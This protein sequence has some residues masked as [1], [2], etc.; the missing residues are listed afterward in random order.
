MTT[1]K[2]KKIVDAALTQSSLPISYL[3][4][5]SVGVARS[6]KTLSKK[7]IFRMDCDPDNSVSTGAGERPILAVRSMT[8][9]MIQ[10]SSPFIREFDPLKDDD[11]NRVVARKLSEGLHQGKVAKVV[12]DIV[13]SSISSASSSDPNES[14]VTSSLCSVPSDV[15]SSEEPVFAVTESLGSQ[16]MRSLDKISSFSS[17]F[18]GTG[19]IETAPSETNSVSSLD[20]SQASQAVVRAICSSWRERANAEAEASKWH[21][22]LQAEDELFGLQVILYFDSG[23]QPQFHEIV[24]A[25]NHN[26]SLA[27]IFIKLNEC[28]D[29]PCKDIFVDENGEVFQRKFPLP[30]TNKEM[31]SQFVHTMMCKPTAN[32]DGLCT[33]FMVI[34]THIDLIGKCDET[35]EDKNDKL[36]D[37]LLPTLDDELIMNGNDIIFPVNAKKPSEKDE[38]CFQ[39]IRQKVSD[40]N[41]AIQVNTPVSF[42]MFFTDVTKYGKQENKRVLELSEC[43]EIAFRLK[44]DRQT[45]EAALIYFDQMNMWMYLPSILPNIVFIDPQ[46]PLDSVN[47][48]VQ[49][50]YQVAEGKIVGFSPDELKKWKEGV[51]TSAMLSTD[52]FTSCFIKDIFEVDDAL[53][54]FQ[55]LFIVAPIKDSEYI[56][57]ANL[58]AVKQCDMHKYHPS[59]SNDVDPL[60]LHF[61]KCRIPNGI[62]CSTHACLR[63]KH[64]WTTSY[65]IK[66]GM[67][68]PVC[69]FRNAVKLQHPEKA[70]KITFINAIKHFEV[71]L[72]LPKDSVP[73][74]ICSEICDMFLDAV[75]SAA[76]AFNFDNSGA[77]VA[78]K[79]S[80]DE[81]V[82]TATLTKDLSNLKCTI[83]GQYSGLKLSQK[84]WLGTLGEYCALLL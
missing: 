42:L 33:R 64:K 19:N 65:T 25:F 4:A 56:M 76:T 55:K 3:K 32:S 7:H 80:C 71:Y 21:I 1:G 75:N 2:A 27:L 73:N 5:I 77:Y 35:L 44:M 45:L 78:F 63:S 34:G 38:A 83:T 72:E 11:M 58:K 30:L 81:Y 53:K 24:A 57:P 9:E 70:I 49:Y 69:L 46:M 29:D 23:G 10:V 17:I 37:L 54:L 6:G 82:H 47:R 41:A 39:L 66:R 74:E 62:F 79:C 26:I 48:I 59:L 28:L 68:T 50:S 36:A 20:N 31:I 14:L 52:D 13:M 40:L 60:F 12:E 61:H 51:V 8:S 84:V 67:S 15:F 43:Q 18:S 16:S 22:S